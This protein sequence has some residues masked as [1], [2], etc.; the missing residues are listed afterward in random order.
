[1][2]GAWTFNGLVAVKSIKHLLYEA[3][4][5]I[6]HPEERA[7]ILS[8]SELTAWVRSA[9]EDRRSPPCSCYMDVGSFVRSQVPVEHLRC[10]RHWTGYRGC[11]RQQ[12]SGSLAIAVL[13]LVCAAGGRFPDVLVL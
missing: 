2:Q 11:H 8:V 9:R 3:H 5:L 6:Q 1:M 7:D 12:G 13:L 4:G 10:A